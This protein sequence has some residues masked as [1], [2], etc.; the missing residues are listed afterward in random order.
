MAVRIE[1]IAVKNC[2]P[3]TNFST[4]LTD[5][6]LIYSENEKGKSYLVEFIIHS[7]FKN[8]SHW[9]DLRQPGQGKIIISGLEN[10][11]TEF[12][13]SKDK[14]IENYLEKQQKGLPSTLSN[15]LIVKEGETE[16]IKNDY[17]IDKSAFKEILSPRRVLDEIDSDKNIMQ[18]IKKAKLESGEIV[19]EKKGDGK[20]YFDLK[21][22]INKIESLI[23]QIINEYEQGE[24]KDLEIKKEELK[25]EKQLLLRAKR[26]EAYILSEKLKEFKIKREKIPESLL[27]KLKSLF[28]DYL[29]IRENLKS[30]D[31]DLT[32][33]KKQTQPL[34]EKIKEK[35]TLL[36][37]KG[38]EAYNISKELKNLEEQLSKISEEELFQ[39]KQSI[40]QYN[41]KL[42][43]KEEKIKILNELKQKSK[44]YL[45]LK[46]AKEQYVTFLSSTIK[47][48]NKTA[49]LSYIAVIFLI[50]GILL[51][52]FEQK[53][54]GVSAILLSAL[55]TL[56]YFMKLKSSFVNYKQME[57]FQ[58]IKK[59]FLNR[60]GSVLEN[61]AQ[62]EEKINEQE[63]S[64]HNIATY[65]NEISRLTVEL[66]S[67]KR[68]IEETFSRM[69][70]HEIEE[71]KWNEKCSELKNKRSILLD[72]YQRLRSKLEELNVEESDYEVNDPGINFS[73]KKMEEIIGEIAGLE[74]LKKQQ[75]DKEAEKLSL[76]K[77][78][79]E[80]KRKIS[81]IF[82]DVL[83]FELEET[84]WKS[85]LNELEKE[86]NSFENNIREIEGRLA[87]LGIS[88]TE[89]E[90][91]DPQKAFSQM[92]LEKIERDLADTE[93]LIRQRNEELSRLR[94]R[95]IQLTGIDSSANWNEMIEKVYSKRRELY[96]ALEDCEAKIVSGILVHETI[97]ELQQQEDEKLLE[98]INSSDITGLI[99]KLTGRYKALSFDEKDI[100]I[101]DDYF[102]FKINELSTG[103]KEQVMIALRIGFAKSLLKGEP[104]FLILD[105]AFQHSD[106][107]KRPLLIDTLFELAQDGWQIIYLTMDDHIRELFREKSKNNKIIFKEVC[108][109]YE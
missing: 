79:D 29:R 14:K 58:S 54:A 63:R 35:E 91:Q 70:F 109:S 43:E 62:L 108:L 2:G 103:A 17:G 80:K 86:R 65:E 64:F 105:D 102:N 48:G 42:A 72:K 55:S 20:T 44:D 50:A 84:E 61:L 31:S 12:S 1:K 89:F 100:I 18:T 76:E 59:E 39:I 30:L 95:I 11:L 60:F 74:K 3:L 82:G 87:G 16:I 49:P 98:K 66:N 45:W 28:D 26:Y 96:E 22:Q 33:I 13:P 8:K 78:L 57:E 32:S 83:G 106:Y 19:I 51:L 101:S 94:D 36:K 71:S 90:K 81:E 75:E 25:Q 21:E 40:T 56:Y 6:N 5:L 88:E 93:Q 23:A 4:E 46:T 27:E 41:E 85:K 67:I 92:E 24:L 97:Q 15:L 7:L 53:I 104:A 9:K 69:G 47:I 99:Q 77:D 68:N 10:F 34:P 37:A 73:K 38:Y 52:F 107:K